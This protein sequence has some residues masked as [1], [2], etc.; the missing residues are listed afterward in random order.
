M[1]SEAWHVVGKEKREREGYVSGFF[2]GGVA[3]FVADP[4]ARGE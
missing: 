4:V 2:A 3:F 1:F